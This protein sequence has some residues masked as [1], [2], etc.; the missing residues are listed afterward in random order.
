MT[1]KS[2]LGYFI[3]TMGV[4][5]DNVQNDIHPVM[6]NGEEKYIGFLSIGNPTIRAKVIM[7]RN[8]SLEKMYRGLEKKATQY[9]Q[10]HLIDPTWIKFDYVDQIEPIIFEKLE[11]KIKRTRRNYFR[12]GIAFDPNFDLAFLEQEINGNALIRKDKQDINALHENN[13]KHYLKIKG[14][15]RAFFSKQAYMQKELYLFTTK[16]Y[17][18]EKANEQL[19]SLYDGALTNGLRKI[20]DTKAEVEKLIIQSTEFLTNQVSDSGKFIYGYFSAF[21]KY[22]ANYN[23]L[24]HSSSLYAMMEGYEVSRNDETLQAVKRGIEYM[25]ND[26]L[27][28]KKDGPD[29]I[30]FVV[31]HANKGE[32]KLGSNATAI[33]AIAKY[34][35]V[36]GDKEHLTVAQDLARGILDM[37]LPD[38]SFIHVLQYPG[39]S[40]KELNRIIY[41]E[42]EAIFALLRLYAIDKQEEWLEASKIS[43]D[44]FIANDYWKHHDHWLSYAANE[45]TLYDPADKYFLFGM[46]NC[47]GRLHF[48]YHRETTF[49]T[50]LEL[51]MAAYKMIQRMKELNKTD[52]LEHIDESYLIETI[53]RRAEFQRVGFFYPEQA[54]YMKQPNLILH[55]FFIRHHSFRVRIDDVEHYLSGYCQYYHDRIKDGGT[56]DVVELDV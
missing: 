17:F 35:E 12:Q 26:A 5:K 25:I 19:Y 8:D 42:G 13:I 3:H 14:S 51:T 24:R 29:G 10:K 41:Y 4:I 11:A 44:Y 34:I 32:I 9:I 7:E 48:I 22:I 39:F 38:N 53:D 27:V 23:I 55:G 6:V 2:A 36:T 33:L 56:F 16:G 45:L 37:R 20:D 43:F 52:L 47:Q 1:D 15:N 54:M 46:K 31:E 50:F 18:K 28:Y 49:P 40:I 21:G 30:A